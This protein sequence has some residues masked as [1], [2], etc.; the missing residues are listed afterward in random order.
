MNSMGSK[1]IEYLGYM[2]VIIGII[3]FIVAGVSSS[4]LGTNDP[5]TPMY[6]LLGLLLLVVGF[7]VSKVA[8]IASKGEPT[9]S[10]EVLEDDDEFVF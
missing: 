9:E 4:V 5:N 3:L 7:I 1:I 10:E 2:V 8:S 6:L